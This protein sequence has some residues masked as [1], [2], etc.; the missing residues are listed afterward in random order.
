[1]KTL[2][3][4]VPGLQTLY[5]DNRGPSRR[6][7]PRKQ[8]PTSMC[9]KLGFYFLHLYTERIGPMYRRFEFCVAQDAG[10]VYM[11]GSTAES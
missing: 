7:E 8:S 3:L 9:C 4:E 10:N 11:Y 6:S 1:M 2:D 5:Y